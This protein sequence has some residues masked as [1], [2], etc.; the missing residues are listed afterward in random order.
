MLKINQNIQ[1]TYQQQPTPRE[2]TCNT[3]LITQNTLAVMF[4]T[5]LSDSFLLFTRVLS[6]SATRGGL[7]FSCHLLQNVGEQLVLRDAGH[8]VTACPHK[9]QPPSGERSHTVSVTAALLPS[10][11]WTTLPAVL[12]GDHPYGSSSQER[13][14]ISWTLNWLNAGVFL[15][16]P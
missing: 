13:R 5:S 16:F 1:A 6:L 7:F 10:G 12:G 15:C 4:G 3:L 11:G 9:R 8:M 14:G 2:T